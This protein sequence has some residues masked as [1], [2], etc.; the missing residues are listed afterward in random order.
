MKNFLNRNTVNARF[1]TDSGNIFYHY[2]HRSFDFIGV[3]ILHTDM[4]IQN[5][6]INTVLCSVLL[7]VLWFAQFRKYLRAL[8]ARWRVGQ[9]KIQNMDTLRWGWINSQLRIRA[10]RCGLSTNDRSV[11][12]DDALKHL[13]WATKICYQS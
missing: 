13:M 4:H 10:G 3:V 12:T 8:I 11:L 5:I 9:I 2:G 6:S 7:V 1:I